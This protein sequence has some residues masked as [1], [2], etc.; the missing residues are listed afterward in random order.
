MPGFNERSR[1]FYAARAGAPLIRYPVGKVSQSVVCHS[2]RQGHVAGNRRGVREAC[3]SADYK[4]AISRPVPGRSSQHQLTGRSRAV[5]RASAAGV[6]RRAFKVTEL[7]CLNCMSVFNP[8]MG[9]SG[10]HQCT[11]KCRGITETVCSI[12]VTKV[13]ALPA[14]KIELPSNQQA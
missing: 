14:K 13:C 5:T 9:E 3:I 4:S 7:G 12:K 1:E 8:H 11:K 2:R 10:R 6:A